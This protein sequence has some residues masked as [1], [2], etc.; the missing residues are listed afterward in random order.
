MQI[1]KLVQFLPDGATVCEF[2]WKSE[3]GMGE[4]SKSQKVDLDCASFYPKVKFSVMI[5]CFK[6]YLRN[7][8]FQDRLTYWWNPTG[9]HVGASDGFDLLHIPELLVV[10]QL[11]EVDDDLVEQSDALDSLV[12][13]LG[14]ELGEVWNARK[15]NSRIGSGNSC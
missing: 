3:R 13:V 12:D 8:V 10:E 4:I 5:V 11:V 1:Y 14:V 15:Q 6:Q 9:R 2:A 7:I